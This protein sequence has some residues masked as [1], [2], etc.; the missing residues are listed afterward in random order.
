MRGMAIRAPPRVPTP[1]AHVPRRILVPHPAVPRLPGD[2]V[3]ARGRAEVGARADDPDQKQKPG[4]GAD[5]DACDG[6]AGEGVGAVW[7]VVGR[8]GVVARDDGDGCRGG[9]GLGLAVF[10]VDEV[11]EGSGW[12][13]VRR[14]GLE[15]GARREPIG[16]GANG[17]HGGGGWVLL[18]EF[19][20]FFS[21]SRFLSFCL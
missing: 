16:K 6:A 21:L 9:G 4:D 5:D 17:G 15:E 7:V 11:G 3:V 1:P 14:G 19:G 10:E 20:F 8:L 2:C 12:M 13:E 18:K